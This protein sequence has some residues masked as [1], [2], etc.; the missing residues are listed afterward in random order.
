MISAW[1]AFLGWGVSECA[2]GLTDVDPATH[3]HAAVVFL[4]FL[5]IAITS[6]TTGA[7]IGLGL[8]VLGGVANAAGGNLPA[9]P[10]PAC[11]AVPSAGSRAEWSAE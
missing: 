7:A 2:R 4:G 8:N 10:C 3:S 5:V 9:A 11:R 1:A 6:A